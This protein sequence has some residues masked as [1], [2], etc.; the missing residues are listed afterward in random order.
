LRQRMGQA[1]REDHARAYEIGG[2]VKRLVNLW[3]EVAE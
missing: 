2:Y 1:A 3:R